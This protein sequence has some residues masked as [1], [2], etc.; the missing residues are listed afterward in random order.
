MLIVTFSRVMRDS[1]GS[2]VS[3]A[4]SLEQSTKIS[5][6][7]RG[8]ARDFRGRGHGSV[9][10]RESYGGRQNTS[11]KGPRQ[12]RHCGHSNHVSK[13]CWK[14]FGR[15][16]GLSYL[17]LILLPRVV[18][19]SPSSAHPDSSTIVLSQEYDRLRQL[20]FSQNNLLATHASA[21]GMHTYIVSPQKIWLLDSGV[22][23]H[24]IGINKSLFH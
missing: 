12:C 7:G 4:P 1:T 13:K 3:H 2:D 18:L 6:H 11:E 14:K 16:S 21:S 20:E 19:R 15:S 17:S 23:S 5:R 24:M 9:R 10:G 22:L 8:R